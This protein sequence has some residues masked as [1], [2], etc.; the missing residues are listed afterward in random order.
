MGY[1]IVHACAPRY[2]YYIIDDA[3]ASYICMYLASQWQLTVIL[4]FQVHALTSKKSKNVNA[5]IETVLIIVTANVANA[6]LT[7]IMLKN[8]KYKLLQATTAK[9]CKQKGPNN[10][11]R[12]QNKGNM[13]KRKL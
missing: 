1:D 8:T 6:W 13:N 10:Y 3:Y 5:R 11:S 4:N 9:T 12:K 2:K 7:S